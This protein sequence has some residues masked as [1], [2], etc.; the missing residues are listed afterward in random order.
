MYRIK[1]EWFLFSS[2]LSGL[3]THWTHTSF[4]ISSRAS[5]LISCRDG[6]SIPFLLGLWQTVRDLARLDWIDIDVRLIPFSDLGLNDRS[7]KLEI[8]LL[9][10]PGFINPA[11]IS[12][13][14]VINWRRLTSVFK[15]FNNLLNPQNLLCV[16]RPHLTRST[17]GGETQLDSII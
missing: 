13:Y 7:T 8:G 5:K 14:V 10:L 9:N 1:H 6:P 17:C 3:S 12:A 4:R 11:E 16:S 15:L 2:T